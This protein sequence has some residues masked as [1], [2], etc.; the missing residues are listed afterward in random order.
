MN[1]PATIAADNVRQ[2][3]R[4]NKAPYTVA[5]IAGIAILVGLSPIAVF[6]DRVPWLA[7]FA[8]FVFFGVREVGGRPQTG[9]LQAPRVRSVTPSAPEFILAAAGSVLLPATGGVM[10]FI[11]WA[12]VYWITRGVA[13][14][15]NLC[16]VAVAPDASAFAFYPTVFFLLLFGIGFVV[17]L[18]R[19]IQQTLYPETADGRSAFYS[20]VAQ[21]RLKVILRILVVAVPFIMMAL[22]F[23]SGTG[24][25][26]MYVVLQIVLVYCSGPT[27]QG[28]AQ[29]H[30]PAPS[31]Q[32]EE[33]VANLFRVN[34]WEVM[35]APATPATNDLGALL[36]V[37]DLIAEGPAGAF[38]VQI[39]PPEEKDS[40]RMDIACASNLQT[41]AWRLHDYREQLSIHAETVRPALVLA[42][43]MAGPRLESFSGR[44]GISMIQIPAE[45]LPKITSRDSGDLGSIA[46]TLL[47]PLMN[48]SSAPFQQGSHDIRTA[49]T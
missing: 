19:Q 12:L 24:A 10:G 20:L 5:F 33:A 11:I 35:V 17:R 28:V 6:L 1:L 3:L 39:A 16:G 21:G 9:A 25:T 4:T 49:A 26:W 29:T 14:L 13:F 44:S 40:E 42:G 23:A 43:R 2:G 18:V 15:L 31:P 37:V 27:W 41:T 7:G 32:I 46:A 34:G 48:N 8:A 45:L 38:A 36:S 47:S 30:T 22:L